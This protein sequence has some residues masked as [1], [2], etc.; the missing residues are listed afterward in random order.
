MAI[1]SKISRRTLV[2]SVAGLAGGFVPALA[3]SARVRLTLAAGSIEI[4]LFTAQAP[5][6]AGDFLKYVD[7]RDYDGGSISRV[8]RQNNDHGHPPIQ[9]IQGGIRDNA[10]QYPPIAHETTRRTGLRHLDGT[11]SIPRD[12]PGTGSGAAFFICIGSQPALDF[13]GQRNPDGQGFAAFGRVSR[14]MEL[15]RA[16]WQTDSSGPSDDPY[17]R[18][19][20]LKHPIRILAAARIA[21]GPDGT[22]PDDW[23]RKV[24]RFNNTLTSKDKKNISWSD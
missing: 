2:A 18:G 4:D 17:T 24:D 22:R 8:V 21:E 1:E 6:S 10:K 20:M 5:L 11:I 19:Q 3:S 16:V 14:G 15:V 9:V 13:G 12:K 23:G 7:R